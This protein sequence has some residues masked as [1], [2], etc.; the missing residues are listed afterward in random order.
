MSNSA[1]T[2]RLQRKRQY[3]RPP[4]IQEVITG[5]ALGDPSAPPSAAD[6]GFIHPA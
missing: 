2:F 1:I 5:R 4:Y 6:Y 3:V